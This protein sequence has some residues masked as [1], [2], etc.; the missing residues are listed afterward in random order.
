MKLK[1]IVI[2]CDQKGCSDKYCYFK[3]ITQP[4]HNLAIIKKLKIIGINF[5]QLK[6]KL[7]K[8]I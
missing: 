1:N 6:C 5:I 4:E 3:Y 8:Y 2:N 7:K